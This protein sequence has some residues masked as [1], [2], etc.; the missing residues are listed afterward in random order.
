[1]R[2]KRE[3][4]NASIKNAQQS[5]GQTSISKQSEK[6]SLKPDEQTSKQQAGKQQFSRWQQ[7]DTSEVQTEKLNTKS[8]EQAGKQQAGKQ[9]LSRWQQPGHS[10]ATN[11][12]SEKL[13]AKSDEQAD[14]QQVSRW[15]QIKDGGQ[16]TAKVCIFLSIVFCKLLKHY[17]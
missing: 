5:E 15:Q 6:F 9:Q 16:Q 8:G 17:N 10:E 7:P 14:K 11:K 2:K 13:I 3:A 4:A 12:Q 1:M